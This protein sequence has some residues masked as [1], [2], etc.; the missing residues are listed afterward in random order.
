MR[1]PRLTL[2]MSVGQEKGGEGEGRLE[3]AGG[4]PANYQA[5]PTQNRLRERVNKSAAMMETASLQ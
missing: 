4:L 2:A 1:G 5:G 3:G